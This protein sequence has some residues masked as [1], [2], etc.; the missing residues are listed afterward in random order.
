MRPRNLPTTSEN[1]FEIDLH[2]WIEFQFPL[3]SWCTM[4]LMLHS[5]G[6]VFLPLSPVFPSFSSKCHRPYE[7]VL[8]FR[9]ASTRKKSRQPPVPVRH[10]ILLI[11]KYL[12]CKNLHTALLFVLSEIVRRWLDFSVEF[13]AQN[14]FGSF[15]FLGSA[16]NKWGLRFLT[17]SHYVG[18]CIRNYRVRILKLPICFAV[19]TLM[20]VDFIF[21]KNLEKHKGN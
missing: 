13:L 17:R 5:K 8:P 14:F 2:M 4:L 10:R 15:N 11:K 6:N 12:R 20:L 19:N 16:Y 21:V 9:N 18:I 7:M 3:I 1:I